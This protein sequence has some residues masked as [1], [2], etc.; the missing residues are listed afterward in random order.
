MLPEKGITECYHG[1]YALNV[2]TY[3]YRSVDFSDNMIVRRLYFGILL[4]TLLLLCSSQTEVTTRGSIKII[5]VCWKRKGRTL[6]HWFKT[7]LFK[8]CEVDYICFH[9]LE[10]ADS[11]NNT[12]LML[13]YLSPGSFFV[14]MVDPA[15][16][17][18]CGIANILLN[19][20]TKYNISSQSLY[21][22]HTGD[23]S[24]P[25]FPHLEAFYRKFRKVYRHFWWNVDPFLSLRAENRLEWM[26]M[27]PLT[28]VN[29]K[30]DFQVLPSSKRQNLLYFSGGKVTNTRRPGQVGYIQK[31]LNQSIS[32]GIGV[33]R[34]YSDDLRN[35]V[36]CINI[37]GT[38]AECF[39]F[40]ESLEAGCIPL[41]MNLYHDFDYTS[42]HNHQYSLLLEVP[43]EKQG[44]YPFLW[45]QDAKDLLR[46]YNS[47]MRS[48][49]EGLRALD[50]LQRDMIVW[51]AK[52]KE[53]YNH[54]MSS[55]MCVR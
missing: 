8:S 36:F 52:V 28:T 26:P 45:A 2:T 19:W 22:G 49:E 14:G 35:S 23:E 17:F 29:N 12:S 37:R 44:T 53:H 3:S 11:S 4:L 42:Q 25:P 1:C 7:V 15:D 34:S 13:N 5:V 40:Y 46:R 20:C 47:Y 10:N 18:C 21:F 31:V 39:R 54:V 43:W 55:D 48:G 27:G 51:Y 50:A 16:P 9:E 32:G 41:M 33:S 24:R 6:E 30:A 38:S